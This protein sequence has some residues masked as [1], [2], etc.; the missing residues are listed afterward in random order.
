MAHTLAEALAQETTL[1]QKVE[2]LIAAYDGIK[3]QL[4][5]ALAGVLTPEQQAQV[6]AIFNAA[7]TEAANIDTTLNPTTPP[8]TPT[9]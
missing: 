4:D 7:T 6:D 5:A 8:T 1:T 3:A 2:A 9:P